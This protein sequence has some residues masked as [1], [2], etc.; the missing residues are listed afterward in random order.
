MRASRVR[1]RG[2]RT[3]HCLIKLAA[4]L[5]AAAAASSAH[6][7]IA[8]SPP[9]PPGSMP[10]WSFTLTPYVWLPTISTT[11]QANTPRGATVSTT[12][13]ASVGDYISH[14]NFGALVGGVARYDRFSVMTDLLYLNASLTT[15]ASHLSTVNLGPG[16]IN[17]P[18]SLQ[19]DTGTRLG[20]TI[21]SLAGGYT[22]LQGR[23]GNLDA[24]AGLRML[25]VNSTTNHTLSADILAPNRTIALTRGGSLD[26]AK[27]YFNGV[28]GVTGRINI[29][30][31]KFYLPF[32]LDAGG[33]DVPFTW[34][35]Y[36]AV[37]YSVARWADLSVGYR[38]L[39]FESDASNGVRKLSLG[40]VALAGNFRF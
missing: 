38:Y 16:P 11:L 26:V 27:S 34:E 22:L 37:A 28:G 7:Q 10:G 3:V 18:R 2:T 35:A 9:P 32:Y 24:V 4:A 15:S 14:I 23:W 30:N 36:G 31:S 6:A 39:S 17:I 25:A 21:W 5:S 19:L 33:G 12:I 1:F 13:S 8:S 29:P 40:G 20:T